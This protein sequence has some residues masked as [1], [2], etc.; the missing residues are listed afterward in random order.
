M[1]VCCRVANRTR[2]TTGFD[3][4][5]PDDVPRDSCKSPARECH[6]TGLLLGLL[7]LSRPELMLLA[8]GRA[9]LASSREV[10]RG[11]RVAGGSEV[12]KG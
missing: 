7:D 9:S 8:A 5:V 1:P 3:G 2:I 12:A 11:W 4:P 6:A 10:N